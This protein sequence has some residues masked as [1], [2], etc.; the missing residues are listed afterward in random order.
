MP[1]FFVFFGG[2]GLPLPPSFRCNRSA[3]N[4]Y[5]H[6]VFCSESGRV[7]KTL[8]SCEVSSTS[9][10]FFRIPLIRLSL[11][12]VWVWGGGEWGFGYIRWGRS[13]PRQDGNEYGCSLL[14]PIWCHLV[15]LDNGL[16]AQKKYCIPPPLRV[17][18]H[19]Q[20]VGRPLIWGRW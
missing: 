6:Q 17:T 4:I 20:A 8:T 5:S 14:M 13:M 2:G 7:C 19:V 10:T 9:I 1:P 18:T 12:G 15:P 16:C 11:L 3:N